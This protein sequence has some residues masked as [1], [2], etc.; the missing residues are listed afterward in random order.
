MNKRLPRAVLFGVVF[1]VLTTSVIAHGQPAG[2]P[3]QTQK[4]PPPNDDEL[5]AA[6]AKVDVQ[7][8]ARDEEIRERL[9]SVL[10]ATGWFVE[11]QVRVEEGVVFLSGRTDTDELKKWAGD[12]ARNTQ[13]VVAVANRTKVSQPSVWDFSAAWGGLSALWRDFIRFLPFLV[14]GLFI[15]A[16]SAGAGWLA[17]RSVRTL[18][19]R[20]VRAKLLRGVLAF[21]AGVFVFLVGTYVVLRVSGLTQLALTVVGGTGLIGLAVG[22]A[23]RDI[24]ENFLASIFLSMQQPFG[25][26]DLIEAAGVTGFVQQLN[27]RTTVLMSLDGNLVQI[28]NATVY[29]STLRNFTANPNRREDFVVGIGYDDPIDEAQEIARRVLADHPAVLNEPEPWVLAD[30][31][32]SAT[33]NLRIYFWLDGREHSWLKVR[34]SVIRLVKRAFQQHGISMPDEAREVVFPKGIPVTLLDG[35]LDIAAATG[36]PE[37]AGTPPTSQ[38]SA[39]STKAEAGL[40]SEAAVIEEQARKAKPLDEGENLLKASLAPGRP[41]DRPPGLESGSA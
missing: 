39:V 15:L 8:V 23:F 28:P 30:G 25:T 29:K 5:S 21:G 36:P 19:H 34:S 33:I 27:V 12:L 40:S 32:G 3:K 11:P 1:G 16:L 17:T 26:G 37:R 2:Q 31:F 6:P 13:D 10:E 38:D 4:Q 24:T 7:P 22:I 18:L 9:Q 14:F 41:P 35:K 20:R